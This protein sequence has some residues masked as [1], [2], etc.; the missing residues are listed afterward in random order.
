MA[1]YGVGLRIVDRH[2]AATGLSVAECSVLPAAG[3]LA[4]SIG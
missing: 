1:G 3:I 2:L 4:H